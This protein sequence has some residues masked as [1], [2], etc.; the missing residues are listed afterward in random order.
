MTG[1]ANFNLVKEIFEKAAFVRAL[2][3]ELTSFGKG[4]CETQVAVS[5]SLRQQHGLAHAG[6]IMTLA[7]HTCGG[8]AASAV[9][10]GRD[11]ITVENKVSFLR[12]ASG[13]VLMCRAEVL[14]AGKSLVFVEATVTGRH[15][16]ESVLVAKASSTLAVIEKSKA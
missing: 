6:A 2:G 8:A 10:E 1:D 3:I 16:S 14:R 11:V 4:W 5:P 7:D 9:P 12:P 15:Q 13:D